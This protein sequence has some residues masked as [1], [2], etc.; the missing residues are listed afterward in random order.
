MHC[1]CPA[2]PDYFVTEAVRP[3]VPVGL[4]AVGRHQLFEGDVAK[5][6]VFHIGGYGTG[7]VG[8]GQGSGHEPGPVGVGGC[9]FI[10]CLA[11]Q[12][13]RRDIEVTDEVRGTV[14]GLGYG[15]AIEVDD[16]NATVTNCTFTSNEATTRGGA[17][18]CYGISQG[19]IEITY[20][21]KDLFSDEYGRM[22]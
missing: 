15:G 21:I 18:E 8:R 16:A 20:L 12:T 14:V 2:H 10:R 19:S 9:E 4:L 3:E 13:G 17:V 22:D 1:V 11:R 5:S 7:A 6:R